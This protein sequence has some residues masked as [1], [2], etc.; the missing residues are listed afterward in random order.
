MASAL[1]LAEIPFW[2]ILLGVGVFLIVFA[3]RGGVHVVHKLLVF[4]LT[5]GVLALV[6]HALRSHSP[7]MAV[8]DSDDSYAQ[9]T[10]RNEAKFVAAMKAFADSDGAYLRATTPDGSFSDMPLAP[11]DPVAVQ[12]DYPMKALAVVLPALAALAALAAVRRSPGAWRGPARGLF[13]LAGGAAVL[14]LLGFM[15]TSRARVA[16]SVIAPINTYPEFPPNAVAPSDRAPIDEQWERLTGPR[17][18]LDDVAARPAADQELQ[19]A[20]EVLQSASEKMGQAAS[21]GWIYAAAK[22]ILNAQQPSS[23]SA[24]LAAAMERAAPAASTLAGDPPADA[25]APVA[26]IEAPSVV[27]VPEPDWVKRPPGLVGNVRKVVVSAG[28]YKTLDECHA[29]LENKLRNVVWSHIIEL[30]SAASGRA[31][32]S[33]SLESLN[34]GT[35]YIL[36]ELC[37]EEYVEDVEASFGPMKRAYALVEF[38]QTQDAE[39]LNR[40]KTYAR[41]DRLAMAGLGATFVVGC[42][43]LA[44]GLLKVDTWTRGY[45][46]KRLFIGVPAAIIGVVWLLSLLA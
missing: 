23:K 1:I 6:V 37:T 12:R 11:A 44:F 43:A 40:W 45:Y 36:R 10:E 41:R 46:S 20:A 42:L 5:F 25:I 3:G 35:D 4:M 14:V 27:R 2:P 18:A 29:E 24:A 19:D 31:M 28:P 21:Q 38:N 16:T 34:I 39:L 30:A 17:I 13:W 15:F 7:T 33:P 22:A 9:I 26:A 8:M 32:S